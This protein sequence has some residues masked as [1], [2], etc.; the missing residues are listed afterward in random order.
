VCKLKKEKSANLSAPYPRKSAG[1]KK[2]SWG[3]VCRLHPNSNFNRRK[4]SVF[5]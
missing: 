3:V 2:T 1:N 5:I 4:N